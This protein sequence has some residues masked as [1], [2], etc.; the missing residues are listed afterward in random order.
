MLQR[1]VRGRGLR[2]SALGKQFKQREQDVRKGIQRAQYYQ[3]YF[4][5]KRPDAAMKSRWSQREND[6]KAYL[7]DLYNRQRQYAETGAHPNLGQKPQNLAW[8]W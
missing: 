4:T 3:G 5:T 2:Q 7:H 1:V 6:A 8:V